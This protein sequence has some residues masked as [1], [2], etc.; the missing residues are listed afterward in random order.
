MGRIQT[1]KAPTLVKR[2]AANGGAIRKLQVTGAVAPATTLS[3]GLSVI[4]SGAFEWGTTE[5]FAGPNGGCALIGDTFSSFFGDTSGI[6]P[7]S[8]GAGTGSFQLGLALWFYQLTLFAVA[9][10]DLSSVVSDT[11]LLILHT[12]IKNTSSGGAASSSTDTQVISAQSFNTG[13]GYSGVLPSSYI[14]TLSGF[15]LGTPGSDLALTMALTKIDGSSGNPTDLPMD[16]GG[17]SH[18][19]LSLINLGNITI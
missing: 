13:A 19:F 16:D 12:S 9:M 17:T 8:A 1:P 18:G 3:G 15:A 5:F 11:D 4:G 14:P 10:P 7:A 2:L 6:T